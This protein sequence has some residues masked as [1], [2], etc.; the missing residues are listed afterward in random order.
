MRAI[1]FRGRCI[2]TG[3]WLYGY[4]LVNRGD[5][6]IVQ[7]GITSPFAE[8]DDFKVDVETV[9]Q[10]TGLHDKNGNEIYEGDILKRRYASYYRGDARIVYR[11]GCVT[12]T[13]GKFVLFNVIDYQDESLHIKKRQLSRY[14]A[15][16]IVNKAS[17]VIGNIHENKEL[18]EGG[19]NE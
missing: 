6:Y 14:A 19:N 15:F 4:Y 2:K 12:F 16:D 8:P 10:F 18:L 3:E 13:N 17:A 7:D 9:G 11:I 5:S 1:K